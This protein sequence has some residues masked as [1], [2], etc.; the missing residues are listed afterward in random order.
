MKEIIDQALCLNR[1]GIM[2]PQTGWA[3]V[4]NHVAVPPVQ[5]IYGVGKVLIVDWM[6]SW[7]WHQIF[8]MRMNRS[9]FS[10]LIN[11]PVPGTGS[12][13]ETEL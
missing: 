5:A 9:I 12:R 8:F 4:F 6:P 10:A 1:P 3:S 11:P 7:E 2:P 13:E